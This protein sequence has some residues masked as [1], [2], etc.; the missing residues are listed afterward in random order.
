MAGKFHVPSR[1]A[2]G[3]GANAL[4]I[5]KSQGDESKGWTN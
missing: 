4:N 1:V 2:A 3:P 5:E